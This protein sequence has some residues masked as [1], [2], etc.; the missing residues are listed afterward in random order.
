MGLL[1]ARDDVPEAAHLSLENIRKRIVR[2][3]KK[4]KC[5]EASPGAGAKRAKSADAQTEAAAEGKTKAAEKAKAKKGKKVKAKATEKA[6][7]KKATTG[8][9]ATL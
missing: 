7:A 4:R 5:E 6:K 1:G 9:R 8:K 3:Q 2:I